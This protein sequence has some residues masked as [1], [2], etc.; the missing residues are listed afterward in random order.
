MG[1]LKALVRIFSV[2]GKEIVEVFRRPGAVLSLVLGPFLILAIFGF[3]Y[4]G[5]KKDLQAIIVINP[6][7]TLPQDA[8]AYQDL[9][10]RGIAVTE[11][12]GDRAAAEAKLRAG[13]ADLVIVAP[14]D[15]MA[16]IEAGQQ[17]D[18]TVLIDTTDPVAANY[19]GFL[20]GT[21][22]SAV[23]R[24]IYRR[25]AQE[26]QTYA[27]TIGGKDLSQIPPDVI[28]SPTK[29]LVQN[30]APIAPSVLGFYG[31]AALALV[32]QHLAVTLIALSIVRERSGGALDRFRS[33][34]LRATELVF[35]KVAAFGLLGGGIAAL[36]LWLLVNVLGVPAARGVARARAPHLGRLGFGTPG[37]AAFPADAPRLD[38]LQ[39]LRPANRGVRGAGPGHVLLPAR[40][41][42]HLA[43]P[44]PDAHGHVHDAVAARRPRGDRRGPAC[45]ELA[46][47]SPGAPAGVTGWPRR[48]LGSALIGFGAIGLA[49]LVALAILVGLSLDGLGRAATDLAQQRAQAIAMLEPAAAALDKAATSAA[50][51]GSS[52]TSA[53]AAARRASELTTRLAGAFDG[54]ALLGSFEILGARPFGALTGEF[55]SVASEARVLS[56]DLETT[57]GALDSNVADSAAVAADLRALA[58]Q[59]ER[60]RTAVEGDDAAPATDAV[61][62]GTLLRVAL[63]VILA[64]LAWLAV[65]AIAAIELGRRWRRDPRVDRGGG[66]THIDINPR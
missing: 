16:S 33:S 1:L 15:P 38:V 56:A 46:P 19:A 59:L 29:A 37:R 57:A 12:T 39:R 2:A 62:A 32:L 51:A 20:A 35:G 63:G 27:I 7:S 10:T 4:G 49:L 25:G 43:P 65:P 11:V 31:P 18:L 14:L 26:G 30:L 52:L 34:P 23:N 24:E 22:S 40:H 66:S 60:L 13:L 6:A 64:L 47:A 8:A 5:F 28:A 55:A 17:A 48:R 42:R 9:G 41:A 21:M 3:G 45:D 53:G 36:S 50:N 44:G 61:T 58:D 54:L